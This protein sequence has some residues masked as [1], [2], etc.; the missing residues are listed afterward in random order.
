M[1]INWRKWNRVLHRDLGYFFFGLT[2]I[3]ALSGIALNHINDWNPSYNITTRDV[4]WPYLQNDNPITEGQVLEFLD[5]YGEKKNYK[6]FYKPQ[7][8]QLKIFIKNGNIDLNLV[9]GQGVL[10]KIKRRPIFHQVNFLHYNPGKVWTWFSD[11]FCI[12]LILIAFTGLFINQGK[13]SITGRGAVLTGIGVLIPIL[14][15]I[16]N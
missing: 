6:K 12:S 10:E 1:T 9:T 5:L 7:G 16:I 4:I 2:I 11:L 15:L 8:D 3:Y 14:F 13:N